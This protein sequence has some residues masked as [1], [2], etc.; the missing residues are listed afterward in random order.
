MFYLWLILSVIYGIVFSL[1]YEYL[2]T[3]P[4]P[5]VRHPSSR[6]FEEDKELYFLMENEY[7]QAWK[8]CHKQR[9]ILNLTRGIFIICGIILFFG[10]MI[11]G[12]SLLLS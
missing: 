5:S 10:L 4:C 1:F 6:L 2:T 3:Y 12:F 11:S 7:N 8:K 9:I